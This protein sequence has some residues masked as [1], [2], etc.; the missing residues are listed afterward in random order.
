MTTA[1]NGYHLYVNPHSYT[2]AGDAVQR[3]QQQPKDPSSSP[4]ENAET[5][6]VFDHAG[7]Q[8]VSVPVRHSSGGGEGLAV[9]PPLPPRALPRNNTSASGSLQQLQQLQQ[10][11]HESLLLWRKPQQQVIFREWYIFHYCNEENVRAL[12]VIQRVCYPFRKLIVFY[13]TLWSFT[14]EA[15]FYTVFIPTLVWLGTPLDA[16]HVASLLCMGQFVTGTLKDAVC[17]PRPPCPPLELRGKRETHDKEY[18]FPSTHASHSSVFA[19]FLYCELVRF[20]PGSALTCWGIAVFYWLNVCFSRLY[21][22]MHWF[23]DLVGGWVV[24]FICVLFHVSFV[25]RWEQHLLSINDAPWWMFVLGYALL[26]VLA[27]S[28]ATPHD[29]CP[30]YLDSLRFSGVLLG[31]FYGFFCFRTKYRVLTARTAPESLLDELCSWAFAK[32]WLLC[33]LLT[34]AAKEISSLVGE[35]ILKVMFKFLAGTYVGSVPRPFKRPYLQ[36]AKLVGYTTRGNGHGSTRYYPITANNSFASGVVAANGTAQYP[37]QIKETASSLQGSPRQQQQQQYG[38]AV[39]GSGM[40][41]EPDGYLHHQQVWSLRTH[42]HWWLWEVH[43]RTLSYAVTG[44]VIAYVCPV[45]LREY[46]EV[47]KD[48]AA[49][50][51]SSA[52]PETV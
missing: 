23:G 34:V 17:C 51:L 41:E 52:T 28:H 49:A 43:K 16:I 21:L 39:A 32:Q 6:V 26:H 14:G 18:G 48:V 4:L 9:P 12:D 31:A 13:F 20:F 36:F 30:C 42:E 40:V 22:G 45:L 27:M 29:P 50:S 46:F 1:S 37:Q 19:Y 15:E 2:V 11:R 3:Y 10:L 5:G 38:E 7:A 33:I 24:A 8:T 44:F 47:G 35:R 25:D